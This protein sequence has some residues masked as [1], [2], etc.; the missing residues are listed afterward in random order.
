MA[1]GIGRK[2]LG[3]VQTFPTL[4]SLLPSGLDVTRN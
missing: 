1:G 3:G 4:F 2:L